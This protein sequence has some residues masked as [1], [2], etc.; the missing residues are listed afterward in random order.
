MNR[1]YQF[2]FHL[3]QQWVIQTNTPPNLKKKVSLSFSFI[4][5]YCFFHCVF[6]LSNG[7]ELFTFNMIAWVSFFFVLSL[8]QKSTFAWIVYSET[9]ILA[10]LTVMENLPCGKAI[11]IRMK[12]RKLI[13]FRQ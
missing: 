4:H 8:L 3:G 7:D 12:E 10:E 9:M 5:P 2:A 6:Q 1:L 11:E 13:L